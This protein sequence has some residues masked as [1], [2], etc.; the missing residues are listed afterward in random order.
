LGDGAS[1]GNLREGKDVIIHS[2]EERDL[3]EALEV[4]N[5]AYQGNLRFKE[6]PEPIS[7]SGRSWRFRLGVED[8]NRPG[9]RHWMPRSWWD[10]SWWGP[11]V[12]HTDSAC[13]H[14]HRDFLY[15]VFERAPY[16]RV[17]TYLAVYE[18]FKNFESTY[19]RTGRLNVG[20]YFEPVHLEDCCDCLKR[21]PWIEEMVPET[22]LGEYAI[23]PDRQIY[24][25]LNNPSKRR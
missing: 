3:R 24:S 20:S 11:K 21:F 16:A 4:A 18:G 9:H 13:Y 15:A 25:G 10:T 7:A 19:R 8:H 12:S 1:L 2:I 22:Y 5:Y 6:G 23:E 14:A 17:V